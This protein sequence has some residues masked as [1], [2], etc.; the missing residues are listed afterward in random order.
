MGK[1]S[2][3]PARLGAATVKQI[4]AAVMESRTRKEL[5]RLTIDTWRMYE[6]DPKNAAALA[7]L[8]AAIEA[9]RD[10]LKRNDPR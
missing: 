10:V 2:E 7:Q 4:Q 3:R 8:R 1:G 9:K 5:N 6:G